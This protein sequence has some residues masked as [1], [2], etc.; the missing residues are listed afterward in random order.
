MPLKA[1]N[2]GAQLANSS[3]HGHAEP[4]LVKNNPSVARCCVPSGCEGDPIHMN[5]LSSAVKVICNNEHCNES[6]FMHKAC[7]EQFEET[8]LNY[9]RSTGRARSW[10]E[11]QR[12]QNLWTK[13][14]YDLAYKACGCKCQKGHLRKDL[15]WQPPVAGQIEEVSNKKKRNRK[16]RNNDKPIL[17]LSQKDVIAQ[18]KANASGMAVVANVNANHT[19]GNVMSLS[20]LVRMRSLSM[21]SAGSGGSLDAESSSPPASIVGDSAVASMKKYFFNDNTRRERHISG[22]IFSRRQDYSSFNT[23]PRHK[24]NSYH[25]KME[26]DGNH[27]NDETRCFILSTL[28]A[29]KMNR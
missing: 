25:I 9:L 11:K 23:L 13:K 22:S 18:N 7:F 8:V 29:N 12:L 14:G 24:I 16:K 4:Y 21:S 15:D 6:R 27:G 3:P 2:E 10:S 17:A 5:D 20:N 28:S 19:N 26:D 1:R